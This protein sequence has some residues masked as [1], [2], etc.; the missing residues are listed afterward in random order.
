MVYK[1]CVFELRR[2]SFVFVGRHHQQQ[3]AGRQLRYS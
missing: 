1:V 3:Q 2:S